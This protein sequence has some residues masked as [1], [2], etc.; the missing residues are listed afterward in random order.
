[1]DLARINCGDLASENSDKD[2][3]HKHLHIYLN[4]QE[5]KW[6]D[7]WYSIGTNFQ[8]ISTYAMHHQCQTIDNAANSAPYSK[9]CSK[10]S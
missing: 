7:S 10:I 5:E 3:F 4:N 2:F 1:M 9:C 8:L 6:S